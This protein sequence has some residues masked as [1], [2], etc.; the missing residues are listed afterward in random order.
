M[1]SRVDS[2]LKEIIVRRDCIECRVLKCFDQKCLCAFL[3][4]F[5]YD[6][7]NLFGSVLVSR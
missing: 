4:C 6:G 2:E 3:S 5:V 7:Q 1:V